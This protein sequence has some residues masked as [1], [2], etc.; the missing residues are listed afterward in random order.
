MDFND[1][2]AEAAF[3]SEA[4]AFLDEHAPEVLDN[5]YEQDSAEDQ[6]RA[7]P[8]ARD[9]QR[10]LYEHGWAA[11]LWPVEYGGR[12]CGPIEQFIW[13]QELGRKAI[14]D[15]IFLGGVGLIGPTLIAHGSEEQKQRHLHAMLRGDQ[16]WCQLFSEPGAGSDLASLATRAVRD[17]DDW[18]VT[19]QKTWSSFAHF[20]DRMRVM[21]ERIKSGFREL[22]AELELPSRLYRGQRT[23]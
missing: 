6:L 3:R 22:R 20:S 7:L 15:S 10:T 8:G 17:G 1:S 21:F 2:P 14:G 4:R 12:G 9:W 5:P 23:E 13:N 18:R 11:L 19:G 16:I